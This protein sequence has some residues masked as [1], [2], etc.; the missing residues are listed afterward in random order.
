MK[1]FSFSRFA[2]L[3]LFVL[4]ACAGKVPQTTTLTSVAPESTPTP[5]PTPDPGIITPENA[6]RL[7]QIK[8]LGMGTAIGSPIYSSDG[9][10]LYQATT[11][12]VFVFDTV[13]YASRLLTPYSALQYVDQIFDL[14][15]D[16]KTLAI[17]NNLVMT[18]GGQVLSH[19][20]TKWPGTR[21][22]KIS[23]DG[24]LLARGYD[25]DIA[26]GHAHVG[27][28]RQ[29]DGKLLQTF[30][31]GSISLLGAMGFSMDGHLLSIKSGLIEHPFFEIYDIQN[32]KRLTDWTG[33]RSVFLPGNQ[34]AVESGGVV[35]IYDLETGIA[36]HAFY[37][38]F[39]T[40][41]PDGKLI[42]LLNFG[43]FKIYRIS[44]EQLLATLDGGSAKFDD[45][46]LRFSPDGQILA[47]LTV[48]Y[49][50]GSHIDNLFL[51]R[52]AERTL[53]KKMDRASDLFNFSPDG[54]FLAI[55]IRNDS[56]QIINTADGSLVAKAGAYNLMARGVAFLPNGHQLI[57]A[58]VNN[59]AEPPS[60]YQPP[61]F[62]FEVDTG[63]LYQTQP[64]TDKNATPGFSKD[65]K[66]YTPNLNF[67]CWGGT[68]YSLDGK[69]K[70]TGFSDGFRLWSLSDNSLLL[71]ASDFSKGVCSLSFSPDGR[72]LAIG[73]ADSTLEL[74]DIDKGEKIYAVK[75]T[76]GPNNIVYDLDFS[77]GGKLL[78]AGFRDGGVRIFGIK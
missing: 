55:T 46:I 29:A 47:V 68:V 7:I 64:A 11:S 33:E 40:P 78:A 22:V 67:D 18:D 65:G 13:A 30:D 35:R 42:I 12:G 57:V 58:G 14:A 15:S 72:I 25:P 36:M 52:V 38:K 31:V 39:A 9:K 10:W 62:F 6:K 53:I 51:W 26:G 54:K 49:C 70:A 50:C 45:A 17:G 44:D 3:L 23:P 28:W 43:Q 20:D 2:I 34:L 48:D 76:D 61:L 77:P 41:S 73:L 4:A 69:K 24:S 21:T 74:W 56:T 1:P 63:N 16:G 32:G 60:G 8:Q 71:S 75:V 66:N 37:G 5:T 19:L 59:M 27:V